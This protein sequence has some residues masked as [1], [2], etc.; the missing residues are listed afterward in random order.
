VFMVRDAMARHFGLAAAR[1]SE[2]DPGPAGF[3]AADIAPDLS[4]DE[5]ILRTAVRAAYDIVFDDRLLRAVRA[6][7]DA[8]RPA[9]FARLRAGYR[10][11]REFPA[12]S[13]RLP[14]ERTAA[15]EV[16]TALGFK[17]VFKP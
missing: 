15:A 17:V 2:P 1:K 12:W 4:S 16:L 10:L 5:N 9:A 8:E 13:V 6:L 11:R 14:V 3:P 7:S